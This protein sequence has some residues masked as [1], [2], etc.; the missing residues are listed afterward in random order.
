MTKKYIRV[1]LI[2]VIANQSCSGIRS[3]L[4]TCDDHS[5]LIKLGDIPTELDIKFLKKTDCI[6]F[7]NFSFLS[8]L[9]VNG[10]FFKSI[11][12]RPIVL[13]FSAALVQPGVFLRLSIL[14]RQAI[15]IHRLVKGF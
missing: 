6:F 4:N 14:I 15:L 12:F 8:Q 13:L 11:N 9:Y 1:Y 10:F 5:R 3:I 2:H 7:F